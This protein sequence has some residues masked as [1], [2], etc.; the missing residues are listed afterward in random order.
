M[1]I[2]LVRRQEMTAWAAAVA[3]DAP[4]GYAAF[5]AAYPGSDLAATARKLQDRARNRP[6]IAALG[7]A[8]IPIGLPSA[9]GGGNSNPATL[10]AN[11]PTCPCAPTP[12]PLTIPP[13]KRTDVTPNPVETTPALPKHVDIPVVPPK[14]VDVSP[15]PQIIVAAPPPKHVD[16]PPPVITHVDPPKVITVSFLP[17]FSTDLTLPP[18]RV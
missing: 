10:A 8:A 16:V 7:Q 2:L 17:M 4:N 13:L 12:A 5:L 1:R 14:R 15:P 9:G 6:Q 3:I 18:A 11:A